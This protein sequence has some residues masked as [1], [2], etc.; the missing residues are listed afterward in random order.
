M[1]QSLNNQ[2]NEKKSFLSKIKRIIIQTETTQETKLAWLLGIMFTCIIYIYT[3][4][5]LL[6]DNLVTARLG[7]EVIPT[8]KILVTVSSLMFG[9]LFMLGISSFNRRKLFNI[10]VGVFLV[11]FAVFGFVVYPFSEYFLLSDETVNAMTHW[12]SGATGAFLSTSKILKISLSGLGIGG[13]FSING[14]NI[15]NLIKNTLTYIG[16]IMGGYGLLYYFASPQLANSLNLVLQVLKYWPYALYYISSEMVGAFFLSALFWNFANYQVHLTEA[17]RIYPFVVLIGQIGQIGAGYVTQ[18]SAHSQNLVTIVSTS[19][20][21]AGLVVLF[22]HEYIFRTTGRESLD[23]VIKEK[24]KPSFSDSIKAMGS[25]PVILLTS[26]IILFYG[27][28]CNILETYWKI[29][30]KDLATKMFPDSKAMATAYF[31]HNQSSMI[32]WVGI[33]SIVSALL[34]G[35]FMRTMGWRFSALITP[36][37]VALGTGLFF[38]LDIFNQL[39]GSVLSLKLLKLAMIIGLIVLVF[40]KATKYTIFDNT[41]EMLLVSLPSD[42]KSQAKVADS[43][44]GRWG[45]ALGGQSLLLVQIFAGSMSSLPVKI[46]IGIFMLICALAW[47]GIVFKLSVF[48]E[49]AEAEDAKLSK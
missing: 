37:T 41:K 43:L 29:S 25:S 30:L 15:K 4:S 14:F 28:T 11:F 34:S 47:T 27:I 12:L 2:D 24:K 48:E 1:S 22:L 19:T 40:V 49:K 33:V 3:I 5:R 20:L 35:F 18:I 9:V 26:M 38:G 16:I 44:A 23:S 32:I 31:S 46:I 7:G 10:T 8:M 39:G 21:G 36:V 45:K 42:V 13:F 17:K 6:K